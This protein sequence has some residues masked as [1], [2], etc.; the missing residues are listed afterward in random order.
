MPRKFTK[1]NNNRYNMK[2]G[3][4]VLSQDK[5]WDNYIFTSDNDY[6]SISIDNIENTNFNQKNFKVYIHKKNEP[7]IIKILEKNNLNCDID[8]Q[9]DIY[10][11]TIS[12][13]DG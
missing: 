9:G 4:G 2:A 13:T 10:I 5:T 3:A 1:K 11:L 8:Y 7:Q 12:R 6:R